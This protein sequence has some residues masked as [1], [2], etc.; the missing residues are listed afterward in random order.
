MTSPSPA[1]R[2]PPSGPREAELAR[3]ESELSAQE[4]RLA[5]QVTRALAD[6][7]ALTSRLDGVRAALARAHQ[8]PDADP[9]VGEQAA[10]LQAARVPSLDVEAARAKAL[11]ARAK[12]LEARKR[13]GTEVQAALRIQQEQTAQVS[14]AVADAEA[15]L[16]QQVE[17]SAA[18][19]RARQEAATRAQQEAARVRQAELAQA[20]ATVKSQGLALPSPPARGA[21]SADGQEARRNGRVRMHTSIDM[22][23]DS[24]FFTGFSMDIS[25]GGVFI[26]TVDAVPRGTQV[27]LDF[28]LP[29]GRPMKVTGVV[30]W[31]RESNPRMPELM[32]GVGV[33]FTGLP[34]EV[35]SVISSFVITRDPMFYPD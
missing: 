10:R 28:T 5:E 21:A 13:M 8:E 25:E 9:Q 11:E 15:A 33:Q 1:A 20:A 31:V 14:R 26:A 32:P 12:A 30:R 6:A 16:K 34:H 17:A 35:A 27:E 18:R 3:A 19:T 22:R 23:S 2:V 7:A 29:G 24:N 4:S